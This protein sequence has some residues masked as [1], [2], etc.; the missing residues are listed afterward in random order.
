MA[1]VVEAGNSLMI[2]DLEVEEAVKEAGSNWTSHDLEAVVEV[3]EADSKLKID[4]EVVVAMEEVVV[5]RM[6]K[7]NV[8]EVVGE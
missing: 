3:E 6:L 7:K 8:A 1:V 4:I 5:D 2:H